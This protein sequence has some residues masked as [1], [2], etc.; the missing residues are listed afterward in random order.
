MTDAEA[1][2]AA[3][4]AG[5]EY[6]IALK[7][8][9]GKLFYN[10]TEF[11]TSDKYYV[12]TTAAPVTW[13]NLP[14]GQTYTIVEQNN[15][16]VNI[17]G[18]TFNGFSSAPVELT[19]DTTV[20]VTNDYTRDKGNLV[21]TKTVKGPVTEDEFNGKL[22]FTIVDKNNKPITV[23]K[24][25][26]VTT[27][28]S[29]DMTLK[30]YFTLVS[31]GNNEFK[32]ELRVE[33]VPTGT[34]K[35]TETNSTF[36]GYVLTKKTGDES[37]QY[38]KKYEQPG[39]ETVVDFVDEYKMAVGSLEIVK[40]FTDAPSN[41]D[42]SKIEFEIEGPKRFNNGTKLTVTYDMFTEGKYV[43]SDAPIGDYIV[44][45]TSRQDS[46][47]DGN[48]KYTFDAGAS[49]V[50]GKTTVAKDTP[51]KVSLKNVYDKEEI[52]GSLEIEKTVG[53]LRLV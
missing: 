32:Y 19:K 46:L 52:L 43:I 44:T 9:S 50:T 47:I 51:A 18:F 53:H 41:L 23:T 29:V 3:T 39:D 36:D 2:A 24:N 35:V 25:D 48:Y 40:G 34:Y 12:I 45:E 11:T 22:T 7:D 31:S 49:T 20:T 14:V 30:D 15:A 16:Q 28:T 21:I 6:S 5:N 26:G 33:N 42:A 13:E 10:G 1:A 4:A 17:E 37:P 27:G 38:V 8:S